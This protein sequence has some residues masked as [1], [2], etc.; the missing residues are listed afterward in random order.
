MNQKRVLSM[1]SHY[2]LLQNYDF[3]SD[4]AA[5]LESLLP[6]ARE[7]IET[8]LVLF[9]K[10]IFTFQHANHFLSNESIIQHHKEKIRI[11]YLHLFNGTYDKAYFDHLHRISQTHVRIA[12]PNHYVNAALHV[13]RA[14]LKDLLIANNRMD[15]LLSVDKLIDMLGGIY[16]TVEQTDL[17]KTIQS[18]HRALQENAKGIFPYVQAIF[19]T[20]TLALKS[21]ECLMRIHEGEEMLP[22]TKFLDIASKTG[23]YCDLSR[24]MLTK[25]FAFFS[26]RTESFSVNISF[27]DMKQCL[28]HGFL[29][30]S[31]LDFSDPSRITFEI[32]E[33]QSL[34]DREALEVF[35]TM[36]R[37]RGCLIAIDDFG[38]GFSKFEHILALKPNL[39]KI[40]GSLIKDIDHNAMH[41]AIVENIHHLAKKLGIATV[42]EYVHSEAILSKVRIIG[43]DFVQGF[44]LDMPKSF[45]DFERVVI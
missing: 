10:R 26:Q 23:L 25:V 41:Y 45:K 29:E 43:I 19:H 16:T 35:T 33:S 13:V 4:D 20:D 40:D 7:N 36:V 38:A 12:L 39:L 8:F 24:A 6:L 11:W 30:R 37:S 27:E 31:L 32:L 44:H 1:H 42:A 28:N 17:L 3:S 22:P 5:R 9:Y 21:Y 14:F 34:E 18:V 15:A 2:T